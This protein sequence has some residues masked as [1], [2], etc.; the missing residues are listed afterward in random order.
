MPPSAPLLGLPHD[1]EQITRSE[2]D[3][4]EQLIWWGR[5]TPGRYAWRYVPVFLFGL[6]FF[7]FAVFWEL[8]ALNMWRNAKP[9]SSGTL[10]SL[11]PLF[12]IPFVLAGFAMLLAPFYEAIRA[13]RIVY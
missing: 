2:L 11:F 8:S 10:G 5:P 6:V 1:V 9:G 13:R 7:G 4:D 3:A 12:G